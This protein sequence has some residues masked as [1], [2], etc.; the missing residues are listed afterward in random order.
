M[1]SIGEKNI[2]F[3]KFVSYRQILD[4]KWKCLEFAVTR[5]RFHNKKFAFVEEGFEFQL[6]RNR[7]ATEVLELLTKAIWHCIG[8]AIKLGN[9]RRMKIR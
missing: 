9:K 1:F 7:N 2:L 6:Q 5:L 4:F 8:V 3:K